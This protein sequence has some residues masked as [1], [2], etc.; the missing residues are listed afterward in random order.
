MSATY[1]AA[2]PADVPDVARLVRGLAEYERE[3]DRFTATEA[4]F[5]RVLFEPGPRAFAILGR[6]LPL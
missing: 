1:R 4:D 6:S 3:L 2:T 5:H